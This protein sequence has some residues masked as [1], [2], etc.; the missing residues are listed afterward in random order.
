MTDSI[1]T[2][3]ILNAFNGYH[4]L[5]NRRIKIAAV[6]RELVNQLKYQSF[7]HTEEYYQLDAEDILRIADELENKK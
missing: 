7:H 1:E 3:E 6:L 5:V 2:Q 4:E